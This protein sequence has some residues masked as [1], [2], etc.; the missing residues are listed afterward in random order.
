M[1]SG[2]ITIRKLNYD[3]IEREEKIIDSISP[4]VY[5]NRYKNPN[6][7]DPRY[8]G[9]MNDYVLVK[10][11]RLYVFNKPISQREQNLIFGKE[12]GSSRFMKKIKRQRKRNKL[13]YFKVKYESKWIDSIN[14]EWKSD[15]IFYDIFLE[16]DQI[17]VAEKRDKIP[18]TETTE[19][20]TKV[21]IR[22]IFLQDTFMIL[23]PITNWNRASFR[24]SVIAGLANETVSSNHDNIFILKL[25]CP[26][27]INKN[28]YELVFDL[29]K[30]GSNTIKIIKN[31]NEEFI[32]PYRIKGK[33]I[34]I[35]TPPI[36]E[37]AKGKIDSKISKIK[38][39]VHTT[40]HIY[41]MPSQL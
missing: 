25:E 13:H 19:T 26:K 5:T 9:F 16:N 20:N 29:K 36:P 37:F 24:Q 21:F 14:K 6:V 1:R 12:N 23:T 8:R 10:G 3:T 31:K 15:Y 33:Y 7:R 35:E 40:N 39:K 41:E 17:A 30:S 11:S 27:S 34:Y 4:Y 18:G 28:K 2:L 38:F 32:C 22:Y